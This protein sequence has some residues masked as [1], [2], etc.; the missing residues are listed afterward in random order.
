MR[1]WKNVQGKRIGRWNMQNPNNIITFPST[2]DGKPKDAARHI[3]LFILSLW[4]FWQCDGN[5]FSK[6]RHLH[7]SAPNPTYYGKVLREQRD[8]VRLHFHFADLYVSAFSFHIRSLKL[9]HSRR[10]IISIMHHMC[11]VGDLINTQERQW[12]NWQTN[13]FQPI[14]CTL[15]REDSNRLRTS[16]TCHSTPFTSLSSQWCKV[17]CWGTSF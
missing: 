7:V 8:I 11:A 2:L 1:K 14:F 6:P 9:V 17:S 16:F 3:H 4:W 15:S 10:V 12:K 5:C 13:S